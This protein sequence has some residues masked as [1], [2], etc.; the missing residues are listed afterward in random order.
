M[1]RGF[2][3]F[4]V[5]YCKELTGLETTS[6]KRLLHAADDFAPRAYEPLLLLAINQGRQDYLMR[7]VAGNGR[8][9]EYRRFL[10]EFE[11]SKSDIVG[12]LERLSDG[13]RYKKVFLAWRSECGALE[14]DRKTLACVA[15]SFLRLLAEKGMT[16]AEACRRLNLNKGNFYAFLK[17]DATRM[18]RGTAIDAYRRLEC[19]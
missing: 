4:L 9:E 8:E 14:R 16:R 1:S 12:Y 6:L 2:E 18:S 19:M 15:D 10:D 13:D 11:S 5:G 17:G 3:G 7:L